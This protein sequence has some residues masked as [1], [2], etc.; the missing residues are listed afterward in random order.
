[1]ANDNGKLGLIGLTG[2]VFGSMIG[3]GIFNIAQNIAVGAGAGAALLS[4]AVVGLGVLFIVLTFKVL[5]NQRPDLNAGIYQFAQEGFGN[6]V[7]FNI[8]W[9]YWLCVIVGNVLLAIMLSNSVG[10]FFPIFLDTW[11]TV[12]FGSIFIWVMFFI[13]ALGVK[14]AVTLNTIVTI[15]KFASLALIIVILFIFFR[16]D[17]FKFDFWGTMPELGSLIKQIKSTMLVAIFCFMGI[18]GAIVMSN[19]A[20]NPK[21]VSRAGII[22]FLSSLVLYSLISVLCYGIMHQAQLAKLEDPSLAYVLKAAAGEWAYYIVI[23]SVIIAILTC[24]IS[25]TLLCTQVPFT[26]AQV[27]I[28]P[29]KFMKV[30]K[31]GTPLFGLFV[32]SI[33]MQLFMV[34]ATISKSIYMAALDMTSVLILPP[35][36]FCGL[37]LWKATSKSNSIHSTSTRQRIYYRLIGIIASLFCLWLIYAGGLKLFMLCSIFFIPGIYVFYV[38]RK[39]NINPGEK[40]FKPFEKWIAAVLIILAIISVVLLAMGKAEF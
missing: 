10:A 23:V 6:Y 2:L 39:E 37:Y 16:L 26:A 35:Y 15:I 25:W 20:K 5:A 24:W 34:I 36:L 40:V 38:A 4:W 29:K 19:Q 12:I 32:S 21:D 17:T 30:S 8:A 18:E 13:I 14:T 22:G 31:N 9:S 1:M 11:P 28:L 3:G 7:G 27:K 33:I